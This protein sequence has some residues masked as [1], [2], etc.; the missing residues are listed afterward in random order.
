MR[1]LFIIGWRM[2]QCCG[3]PPSKGNRVPQADMHVFH[4]C[5]ENGLLH[6]SL[7]RITRNLD[8]GFRELTDVEPAYFRPLRES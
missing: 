1:V 4:A 5:D 6:V 3:F 2:S 8:L 7:S